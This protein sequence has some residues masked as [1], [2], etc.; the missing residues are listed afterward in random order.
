M[1]HIPHLLRLMEMACLRGLFRLRLAQ[2]EHLGLVVERL[3]NQIA[4]RGLRY[5][6]DH[7]SISRRVKGDMAL[8]YYEGQELAL[9]ARCPPPALP[10]LELGGSIGV[11]ACRANQRLVDPTQHWVIEANPFLLPLL[12]HN[13]TLNRCQFQIV[14]VALGYTVE[15]SLTVAR[16]HRASRTAAP[17]TSSIQV[18]ARSLAALATAAQVD[19]FGLIC[20]IEGSEFD[21]LAQELDF[22]CQHVPWLLLELH[23][24]PPH[25]PAGIEHALALL[26]SRGYHIQGRINQCYC[27]T[28][29]A[30]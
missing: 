19:R 4:L 1:P 11:V 23:A 25:G 20:D 24:V 22:L 6:V 21:L 13:R 5:S 18:E 7:P 15:V 12:A 8:G 3:G 29:P 17:L 26:T 10:L 14:P 16:D 30:S 9:L 27:L 2:R 28:L